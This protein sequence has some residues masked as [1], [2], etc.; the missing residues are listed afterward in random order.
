[1]LII[2]ADPESLFELELNGI[3][4]PSFILNYQTKYKAGWLKLMTEFDQC[5][6]L[7]DPIQRGSY[8]VFIPSSFVGKILSQILCT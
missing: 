6:N 4:T 5:K 8:Y 3:F 7:Y 2:V 1:M